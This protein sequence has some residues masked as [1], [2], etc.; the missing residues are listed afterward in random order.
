MTEK[1]GHAISY[2]MI[3]YLFSSYFFDT[4]KKLNNLLVI[5]RNYEYGKDI[6]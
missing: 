3:V 6:I 2:Y 5:S 1:S 4:T